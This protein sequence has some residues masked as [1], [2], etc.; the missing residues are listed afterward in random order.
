MR[1]RAT[2]LKG[3]HTRSSNNSATK[4]GKESLDEDASHLPKPLHPDEIAPE[5]DYGERDG[6]EGGPGKIPGEEDEKGKAE[7]VDAV[8]KGGDDEKKKGSSD[9]DEP[10]E[11][12]VLDY[13]R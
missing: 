7:A 6:G 10:R 5:V 3:F 9:A 1:A 4:H 8:K 2:I 11:A 12:H 13:S